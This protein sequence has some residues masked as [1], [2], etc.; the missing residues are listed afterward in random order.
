MPTPTLLRNVYVHAPFCARRCFYCDFAVSV[1]R[2]AEPSAWLAAL[3]R[4][5]RHLE[6]EE[7]I[8]LGPSLDTVYLGGGTP[9]LLGPEAVPGLRQL[10]GPS[11]FGAATEFTAEANPESFG[12]DVAEAW[13]AA[14]LG[15][16]SLG[17]QS[18][19]EPVLRWMGRTHGADGARRAVQ[20]AKESGLDD[21]SLD[22]IFGL[23]DAVP[24]NW[25][26][27]LDE[28]LRLDVPHVSLYGLTAEADTP[29]GRGVEEGRIHMPSEERYADEYRLAHERLVAAGY[30][31]YEVSNFA[32]PGHHS[33]H[34]AHYWSGGSWLGLGNGAH[35]FIAPRRRWN[36]RSWERYDERLRAGESPLDGEET[37]DN[38]AARLEAVWL[39]LRTRE[40]VVLAPG[41]LRADELVARWVAEDW[42][43]REA[44][45]NERRVAL[46][47][48][49]WLR[50]DRLAVE[51]EDRLERTPDLG[52]GSEPERPEG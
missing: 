47:L 20:I 23:P 4:E 50:L 32:R 29:L 21:L 27:D 13:A 6:D 42:A 34:N 18:F 2:R 46:T 45:Q 33:R 22:L 28:V 25:V 3:E 43:R 40:G 8:A 38:D 7:R 16:L 35:S 37:I 17:T 51:L 26:A 10:L 41:Q 11:R 31:H 15:R 24:R 52:P 14:G 39:G 49:G 36:V 30:E 19:Q 12:T 5:L 1:R 9:S 48:E 44:W